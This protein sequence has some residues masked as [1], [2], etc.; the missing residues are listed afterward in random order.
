MINQFRSILVSFFIQKEILVEDIDGKNLMMDFVMS[1]NDNW[2][3]NL[4]YGDKQF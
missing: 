3:M 2:I 1:A 4:I